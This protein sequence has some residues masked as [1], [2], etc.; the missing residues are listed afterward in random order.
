MKKLVAALVAFAITGACLYLYLRFFRSPFPET[1]FP[2]N[3]TGYAFL[4]DVTWG[5]RG[6][7]KTSLWEQIGKSPRKKSYIRQLDRAVGALENITGVNLRPLFQQFTR[8]VALGFFPAKDG[9]PHAAFVAY[10]SD[11]SDA[12]RIIE[13]EMDPALRRRI[14]DLQKQQVPYGKDT[15]YKYS[16]STYK[17]LALCYL[18]AAH[19]W[20]L[21]GSEEGIRALLDVRHKK[22]GPLKGNRLFI[23]AKKAVHFRYG[24]LFYLDAQNALRMIKSSMSPA[25]VRIWPALVKITGA[26][27][28]QSLSYSVGVEN[29]GFLEEGFLA[30]KR[31]RQGLLKI[32]LEQK[33]RRLDSVSALP[34]ES[35]VFR[36]GTLSD[37]G[38]MWDEVNAQLSTVLSRDQYERWQKVLDAARGLFNFDIRRDLLEPIGQEFGFS[39]EISEKGLS[40]PS[41]MKYLLVLHL[42]NPNRFRETLDRFLSLAALRGTSRKQEEYEGRKIQV[43]QLEVGQLSISPAFYL[44]DS[45]AYFSTNSSFLKKSIDARMQNKNIQSVPDYQRVTKGFPEEVNGLSYTDVQAYFQM[46]ASLL[47][48]QAGNPANRWIQEY[49]LEAE[50]ADLGKNLFGSASYTKIHDQGMFIHTYSSVPTSFLAL[51][52]LVSKVPQILEG[53]QNEE[54]IEN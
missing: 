34:L 40:D 19:H 9:A 3:T 44:E 42:R 15:Y 45:W 33:P 43:L 27:A 32:F 7:E 14:P 41:N 29:E 24:L 10:V 46:Y 8:D 26:D 22:G 4:S 25:V 53:W 20:I 21:S 18:F 12:Q 38:K 13:R 28:L 6:L 2:E 50:F 36:S 11:E 35:K 1:V 23:N 17:S 30:V 51:P 37:F 16:S 48:H 52:V 39:Y 31:E 47:E 49:G 5:R 54:E